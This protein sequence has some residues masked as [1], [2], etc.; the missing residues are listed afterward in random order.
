MSEREYT[1]GTID[2]NSYPV[3]RRPGEYRRNNKTGEVEFLLWRPGEQ[4]HVNG[5][6][7]RMG[8]GWKDY[9]VPDKR[10]GNNHRCQVSEL[11]YATRLEF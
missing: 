6:W 11:E 9:F 3:L 5:Y 1:Y 8:A 7:H 2:P 10:F 4:G